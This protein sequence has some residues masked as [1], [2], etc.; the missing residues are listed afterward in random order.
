M[1]QPLQAIFF[2]NFEN[3]YIPQIL[4]EMYIKQVYK[5]YL[6]GQRDLII[7]DWGGN[8][9]LT[10]Y[11]FKD[12]A[13]KVYCVEPSKDH[14]EVIE[15]L[16]EHNDIKNIKLCKYA[17]SNEN[18]KT[19]FYHNENVTM[20]SLESTVNK[21]DDFEEVETVSVDSFMEREGIDRID[22]LKFDVE[23]S[24]GLVLA[25]EGFKKV[26]DRIKVIVGEWHSWCPMSKNVFMNTFRDLGFEFKWVQG[27]D[28]SV[29][30]AVRI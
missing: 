13:K 29:F 14:Q 28:A 20:F 30:T 6:E 25:S 21:K 2:R 18:G 7:A 24:E 1:P 11:Y 27:T 4:E 19:K 3:S 5:P 15:K 17:I 26:A 16:I 22:L 9:G 8:I 23:G 10:S 12:Y